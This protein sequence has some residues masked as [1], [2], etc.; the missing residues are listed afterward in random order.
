[1]VSIYP[2]YSMLKYVVRLLVS[3]A[4]SCTFLKNDFAYYASGGS[5]A[6]LG[7]LWDITDRDCDLFTYALLRTWL[8]KT[9]Q[10]ENQEH[11]TGDEL[12][13]S[14]RRDTEIVTRAGLAAA[15]GYARSACKLKSL[16]GAAPVV[17]GLPCLS[18]SVK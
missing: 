13:L 1:M 10:D 7:N 8:W 5:P 2:G 15:V 6:V 17:W 11:E 9:W 12:V 14:R 3:A 4:L 18:Y 16:V